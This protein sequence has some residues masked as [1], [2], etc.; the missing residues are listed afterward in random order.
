MINLHER[1]LPTSAGVEPATS[2]SD[3]GLNC[4]LKPVNLNL[5]AKYGT[6]SYHHYSRQQSNDAFPRV[7]FNA[8]VLKLIKGLTIKAPSKIVADNT[9]IFLRK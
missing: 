1:M 6:S 3:L 9:L 7:F 5:S 2:C 4:L 8:K